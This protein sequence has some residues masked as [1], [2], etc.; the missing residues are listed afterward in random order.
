MLGGSVLLLVLLSFVTMVAF[1]DVGPGTLSDVQYPDGTSVPTEYGGQGQ[2]FFIV[3]PGDSYQVVITDVEEALRGTL[4]GVW[5]KGK[6]QD[7]T[8]WQVYLPDQQVDSAGKITTGVFTI[9]QTAG[10]TIQVAYYQIGHE[11]ANPTGPG[12]GHMKTYYDDIEP[13]DNPV[14]CEEVGLPEFQLGP[15]AI[16]ALGLVAW[17]AVR[18]RRKL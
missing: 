8:K 14:P 4:V 5:I 13:F 1:A 2:T 16:A 3:V 18:R 9:P 15:E 17:I 11:T 10:C 7:G 6:N 12:T